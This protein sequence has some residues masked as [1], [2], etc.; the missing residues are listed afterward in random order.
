MTTTT[1]NKVNHLLRSVPDDLAGDIVFYIDQ[2]VQSYHVPNE[3]QKMVLKRL[4]NALENP[5]SLIPL[6]D[7]LNELDN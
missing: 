5:D 1:I 3:V 4:D 6:D 2:L 7:F